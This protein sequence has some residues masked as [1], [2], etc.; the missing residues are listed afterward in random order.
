M[1]DPQAGQTW[2]VLV[3]DDNPA[4]HGDFRKVLAPRPQ[5]DASLEEAESA[6]FG[7]M[8]AA[9]PRLGFRIDSAFQGREGLE[10]IRK[11][12]DEGEPYALAFIDVR[13]PPGWDGIETTTHIW[14]HYPELQVVICTAYS[15]Y[16]WD[17]I[18]HQI[19]YTDNLVILKKP[20]DNVEVLQ[21]THALTRKWE[22][23]RQVRCRLDEL[24]TQVR[25]RTEDLERSNVALEKEIKERV[26]IELALRTSEERF[27]KAFRSNPLPMAIVELR[28]RRLIDVNRSLVSLTERSREDAVNRTARELS[29]IEDAA[30]FDAFLSDCAN[31]RSVRDR[32]MRMRTTSASARDVLAYAEPFDLGETPH[33]LVIWQDITEQL[34]I[35]AQLRQAQKMEA[36]G[37]LA[38]GIAHDFN[39]ILTVIQGHLSLVRAEAQHD[40]SLVESHE[41][42]LAAA[43]RAANLTRQ[44]LTFSRKQMVTLAPL[45]MNELV[46]ASSSMLRRL[47]GEHIELR[48]TLGED[49]PCATADSG[50][51][52]MILM[53]LAVNGRDAMPGGGLL[54]ITTARVQFDREA[55]AARAN[56][57]AGTFVSVAVRD[58]GHGMP[59]EVMEHIFEP[60][61]TTKE[62]GKG[63]GLGL[64]TVY[65]IIRQH[66]GWV[67]VESSEGWG[68]TFTFYL[69]AT[70]TCGEQ[71]KPGKR[72]Q[73]PKSGRGETILVVEDEVAV[74]SYTC[75]LLRKHGYEVVEAGDAIEAGDVWRANPEK[76]RLLITDMIMP[77]G[78]TGRELSEILL[79][80]RPD[81][82]VI[83]ISGY[84]PE[85]A[86]WQPSEDRARRFLV[87]PFKSAALLQAVREC[88]DAPV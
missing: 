34:R 41:A 25:R 32:P 6:L 42:I 80:E 44:L 63:T 57:S 16:S 83:F 65:G 12:L 46:S 10:L 71:E 86:G 87:K 2:R 76:I 43:E 4:I 59:A 78:M 64:A 84:S 23:A 58:S 40:E 66:G 75:R 50:C 81:L 29:L 68:T 49:L 9:S 14:R 36:I 7:S 74:R 33:A 5:S 69:P 73:A 51:I 45:N 17:D 1:N 31:G 77:R 22:L 62:V 35:E 54:E 70:P 88:L 15:D 37:Q 24:D 39:N 53:N 11:A 67:E 26:H 55:A 19:G 18:A 85:M 61:Y 48:L 28:G 21:L 47:I 38:A 30:A 13:M 27:A 72:D 82:K 8:P 20:F 60:F 3:I 52:E 79:E 56:A